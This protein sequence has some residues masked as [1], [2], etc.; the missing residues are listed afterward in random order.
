MLKSPHSSMRQR[1]TTSRR[2]H[3]KTPDHRKKAHQNRNLRATTTKKTTMTTERREGRTTSS[4]NGILTARSSSASPNPLPAPCPLSTATG[5]HRRR[6]RQKRTRTRSRC[7][8]PALLSRPWPAASIWKAQSPIWPGSGKTGHVAS[9]VSPYSE[10]GRSPFVWQ[11]GTRSG[12]AVGL[13]IL[14]RSAPPGAAS[15]LP[16]GGLLRRAAVCCLLVLSACSVCLS[17]VA[18]RPSVAPRWPRER[19]SF[20]T[21]KFPP[22]LA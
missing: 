13:W 16:D 11:T 5:S 8:F 15:G 21:S 10:S 6:R 12:W 7:H 9:D 4:P 22:R 2:N 1:L 18:R 17:A 19:A 20:Q 14:E 3:S